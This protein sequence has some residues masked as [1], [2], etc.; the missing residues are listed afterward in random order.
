MKISL[1]LLFVPV[2]LVSTILSVAQSNSDKATIVHIDSLNSHAEQYADEH[3]PL[4]GPAAMEALQSSRKI[5]YRKGETEALIV[6]AS[7]EEDSGKYETALRQLEYALKASNE[8]KDNS[9]IAKSIQ[10]KGNIETL[11][12]NF[13]EAIETYM[14]AL[15]I[16]EKIGAKKI[17]SDVLN[18]IGIC[19][20]DLQKYDK[21]LEFH[22]RALKMRQ[23][24]GWEKEV[25]ASLQNIGNIYFAQEQDTAAMKYYQESLEMRKK[26]GDKSGIASSLNCIGAIYV[27]Y[28]QNEKAKELIGQ[29]AAIRK[30]IGELNKLP[31]LYGNLADVES[32]S[33]NHAAAI[34][35]L[36]QALEIAKQTKAK[37]D[38]RNIYQSYSV[39]YEEMKDAPNALKNYKLYTL[40]KDSILNEKNSRQVNDLQAKYEATEK[41][42]KI[43]LQQAEID[44]QKTRNVFLSV[45]FLLAAIIGTLLFNRHRLKTKQVIQE[46]KIKQERLRNQS[47]IM[48][49]ENERKHIAGELHDGLGQVLSAARLNVESLSQKLS[50]GTTD[51]QLASALNLIDNSFTEL[52]NISHRM[53]PV[54]LIRFG[55]KAAIQ[56]MVDNL[57]KSGSIQ[58]RFDADEEI[59]RFENAIEINVFR[60][61]QEWINNVIKYAHAAEV[62]IQVMLSENELT[63]MME[64]NGK[65]FDTKL[66]ETGKGNG[67]YNINSRVSLINGQI[68]IDSKINKGTLVSVFVPVNVSDLVLD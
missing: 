52:R 54:H 56:D 47:M 21:A 61:V 27:D 53:M 17:I 10:N 46:E 32:M 20:L 39:T 68:E 9:L 14:Q 7:L 43:K 30:E 33:G 8:I 5:N 18:N 29:A 42:N 11:Q 63:V 6:L 67:W 4:A 15:S 31:M 25:A 65:G 55:L 24:E 19:H 62:S 13:K 59:P 41:E 60:I 12:G 40:Y 23:E 58:F 35:Y 36:D 22:T 45:S 26:L 51:P 44:K 38:F 48:A 66:L 3:S 2:L 34:S 1:P 49:Q 37:R 28:E 16:A 50:V 64:D 57:N